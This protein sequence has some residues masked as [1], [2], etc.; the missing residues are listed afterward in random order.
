MRTNIRQLKAKL[1]DYERNQKVLILK[2]P[3]KARKKCPKLGHYV[4]TLHT[5]DHQY[6]SICYFLYDIPIAFIL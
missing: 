2:R 6:T 4:Q 1:L 3:K 5:F